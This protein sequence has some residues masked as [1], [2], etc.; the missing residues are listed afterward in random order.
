MSMFKPW[1]RKTPIGHW[2]EFST[3]R[4]ATHRGGE[5]EDFVFGNVWTRIWRNRDRRG[6]IY[7][8]V[9]F[10]RLHKSREGAKMSK[11]FCPSDLDDLYR[12]LCRAKEY[13]A[14]EE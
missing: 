2:A 4:D 14:K 6:E 9:S 5:V 3:P 8:K 12:A 7:F 11:S 1:K 10:D 13:F